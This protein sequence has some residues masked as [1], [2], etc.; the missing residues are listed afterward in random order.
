MELLAA[1]SSTYAD[2]SDED[3]HLEKDNLVHVS[4]AEAEAAAERVAKKSRISIGAAAPSSGGQAVGSTADRLKRYV[5]PDGA[6]ADMLRQDAAE[7]IA[8]LKQ[9]E[10][11]AARGPVAK[12]QRLSGG[13]VVKMPLG[14]GPGGIDGVSPMSTSCPQVSIDGRVRSFPHV[15]GNYPGFVYLPMSRIEGLE[16]AAVRATKIA[17]AVLNQNWKLGCSRGNQPL[18]HRI[19][20]QNLHLSLS[21]TFALRYAQIK[22]VVEL[23]RKH[24]NA[25]PC[26][27]AAVSGVDL[28]SNDDKTRSFVGLSLSLG[29]TRMQTLTR[30]VNH[31]LASFSL[32]P[33]YE[34]MRFHVS[35][36]WFA[37]ALPEGVPCTLVRQDGVPLVG[38]GQLK[39]HDERSSD[40]GPQE[41]AGDWDGGR[42]QERCDGGR[43]GEGRDMGGA[44]SGGKSGD[45]GEGGSGEGGSEDGQEEQGCRDKERGSGRSKR[46]VEVQE[47]GGGNS[48]R[49]EEVKKEEEVEVRSVS[50]SVKS[51]EAKIGS[52]TYTFKLC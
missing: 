32:E 1:I 19:T 36:A 42:R 35:V 17:A 44:R 25:C 11:E 39:R 52:K 50:F 13:T 40:G 9:T 29:S 28:Y 16:A 45:L 22:P 41:D 30:A 10:A 5:A 14:E 27:D 33:F 46:E 20:V 48:K 24:L 38:V 4:L 23:L 8:S 37:G 43:A 2:S 34:E 12:K 31:A 21:R 3:H 49:E 18:L 7:E 51:I 15:V 26:F 6:A 47:S